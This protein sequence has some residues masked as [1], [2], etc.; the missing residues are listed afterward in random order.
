MAQEFVTTSGLAAE[1]IFSRRVATCATGAMMTNKIICAIDSQQHSARAATVAF[2]LAKD[3]GA[4][5]TL[6]MVNPALPRSRTAQY[7]WPDEYIE[8]ILNEAGSKARWAGVPNV[9]FESRRGINIADEIVACADEQEADY[10]VLGASERSGFM[11]VINGSVSRDVTAKA[12]CPVVIVKRVRSQQ[13]GCPSR[14]LPE[15]F[16]FRKNVTSAS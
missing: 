12:N 13:R 6:C 8:K 16:V 7:W 1:R 15:S 3:L 5:L 4:R 11:R 14:G 2:Q 10:I 9:S